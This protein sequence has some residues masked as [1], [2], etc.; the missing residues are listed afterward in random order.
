[1]PAM[2]KAPGVVSV[3]R[4]DG[5]NRRLQNVSRCVARR[6]RVSRACEEPAHSFGT[7][8]ATETAVAKTCGGAGDRRREESAHPI[9]R[10]LDR[11]ALGGHPSLGGPRAARAV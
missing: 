3:P 9:Y 4:N 10:P 8:A 1:M 7:A 11:V 5:R 2:C 6:Q